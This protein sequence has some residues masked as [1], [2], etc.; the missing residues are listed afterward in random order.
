[1]PH[2]YRNARVLLDA[3]VFLDI[4]I[5]RVKGDNCPEFEKIR[6]EHQYIIK[7]TRLQKHYIG[8]IAK[9]L[10]MKAQPFLRSVYDEVLVKDI[11]DKNAS[12]HQPVF[13]VSRKD[14]FLY[15]LAIEA[16]GNNR[17]QVLLISNDPDQTENFA[18][19]LSSENIQIVDAQTYVQEYC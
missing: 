13:R 2:H 19:M 7:S 9:R 18:R 14:R 15:G 12:R 8:A 4:A 3:N 17:H 1:M 6:R 10:S 16:K 5:S 11:N